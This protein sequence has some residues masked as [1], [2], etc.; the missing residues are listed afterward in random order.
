[1][2]QPFLDCQNWTYLSQ[3]KLVQEPWQTESADEPSQIASTLVLI[4]GAHPL[5][6]RHHDTFPHLRPS[7]VRRVS[8]GRMKSLSKIW[9]DGNQWLGCTRTNPKMTRRIVQSEQSCCQKSIKQIHQ[10]APS[11]WLF[12]W[13]AS[14]G[15]IKGTRVRDWTY[16][17]HKLSSELR[18]G[19]TAINKIKN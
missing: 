11:Q 10:D 13:G 12:L 3:S 9:R 2:W 4:Q 5:D 19:V 7:Q 18:K 1:M 14:F 17:A 16:S 8:K 15:W 6:L